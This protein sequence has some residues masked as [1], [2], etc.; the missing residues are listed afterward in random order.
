MKLR[1]WIRENLFGASVKFAVL[2]E[3]ASLADVA[4]ARFQQKDYEGARESL[5]RALQLRDSQTDAT[6]VEFLLA[7][8]GASW[9]YTDKYDDAIAFFSGYLKQ[10]PLEARAYG[11][12]GA[13]MWYSDRLEESLRDYSRALALKPDDFLSQNGRGHVLALIGRNKEALADLDSA[14]RNL[15]K[16]PRL[17]PKAIDYYEQVEAFV[18]NGRAVALAGGGD[19]DS[20][21][22][23]FERSIKLCPKNAW[24]YYNRA[25]I[26]DAAGDSANAE[27]DY[28]VALEN[29]EPPLTFSQKAIAQRRLHELKTNT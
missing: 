21:M 1:Q 24:V 11:M 27:R 12:R 14:L 6:T 29:E 3:I 26:S 15:K 10:Y 17:G 16:A 9:L 2:T 4:V 25:K 5:L 23:E 22:Q 18:R 7:A 28:A 13:A 19:V 20:A 8:L